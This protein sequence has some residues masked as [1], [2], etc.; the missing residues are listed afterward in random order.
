[1][2]EAPRNAVSFLIV[3]DETRVRRGLSRH[4]ARYGH[5][6]VAA[7]V[8]EARS[9][10]GLVRF[11]GLIVD[12]E[13]GDGTG[14]EVLALAR[15]QLPDALGL[16]L[17]GAVDPDALSHAFS[18]DAAYL[19]K[20]ASADELTQFADR[21]RARWLRKNASWPR[22]VIGDWVVRYELTPAEEEVLTLAVNGVS[23]VEIAKRRGV[24]TATLKKQVQSLL[25]KTGDAS[26]ESAANRALRA[27]LGVR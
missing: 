11:D 6:E 3:D 23:R 27:A 18:L 19:V 16:L 21:V 5:V 4:F 2:V 13:L 1:M 26:L 9:F 22:N 24:T 12:V 25:A 17:S 14:F 8:R 10:L 20:P 15:E 7:T